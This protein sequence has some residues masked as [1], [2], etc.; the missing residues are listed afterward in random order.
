MIQKFNFILVCREP[1]FVNGLGG[2]EVHG[3]LFKLLKEINTVTATKLHSLVDKPFS[4]GPLLGDWERKGGFCR[5]SLEKRYM[6]SVSCL[7]EEMIDLIE[8]VARFWSGRSVR[9]GSGAYTVENIWKECPHGV[10]Y[11]E[12][13][14]V[15]RR[16]DEFTLEFCTPTSFRQRGTQILFPLP[17]RVFGSLLHKW[18]VFSP[19]QLHQD[20]DFSI[21]RVKKYNLH[22]EMVH[23]DKYMVAGF[24]GRCTYTIPRKHE[25]FLAFQLHTLARFAEFASVGYKVTMGLGATRLLS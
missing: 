1:G 16:D 24:V 18:N 6:F 19:V 21:V 17:E 5:S 15:S 11:Q 22:T 9:L 10:T 25:D 8:Q 13:L 20:S 14:T 4:L 23:F 12:I 3:L 7:N 2:S